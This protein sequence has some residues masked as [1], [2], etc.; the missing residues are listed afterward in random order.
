M[1][2]LALYTLDLYVVQIAGLVFDQG[3]FKPIR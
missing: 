1:I 3:S 2:E